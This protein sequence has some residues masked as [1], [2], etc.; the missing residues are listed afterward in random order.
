MIQLKADLSK[1]GIDR[2][3]KEISSFQND[4]EIKLQMFVDQLENIGLTVGR[5]NISEGFSQYISIT[6][7][8]DKTINGYSGFVCFIEKGQILSK[9]YHHKND[10]TPLEYYISPLLMSEFG[11]GTKAVPPRTLDDGTKVGQGTFPAASENGY[12]THAYQDSWFYYDTDRRTQM[13]H[14]IRPTQPVYKAWEAMRMDIARVA[15]TVF[16]GGV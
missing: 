10:A 15:N 11:A 13:A 2:L 12:E 6:K 14:G 1:K 4:F 16:S 7:K 5:A 8:L 9:W 3:V